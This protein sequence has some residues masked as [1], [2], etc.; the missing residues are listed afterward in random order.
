MRLEH[1]VEHHPV[2]SGLQHQVAPHRDVVRDVL[3]LLAPVTGEVAVLI[4]VANPRLVVAEL[5]TL[6][7]RA[8]L[9]TS[10]SGVVSDA[11]RLL[12]VL[13]G[14]LRCSTRTTHRLPLS[15]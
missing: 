4:L 8:L 6:R 13:C 9:N 2:L 12:L 15:V 7:D 3:G 1:V 5:G 10:L 11:A 14:W